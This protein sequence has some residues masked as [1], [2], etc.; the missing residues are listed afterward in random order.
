VNNVVNIVVV[1]YYAN[2]KHPK[3]KKWNSMIPQNENV[4]MTC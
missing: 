2:I 3:D 4:V 1:A